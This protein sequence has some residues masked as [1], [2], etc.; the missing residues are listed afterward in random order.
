MAIH[1][2][3]E[4]ART[5]DFSKLD[6]FADRFGFQTASWLAFIAATQRAEPVVASL[7]DGGETVG[8]FTGLVFRRWGLKLLGSPFP[9]WTTDYMGFNLVPGCP[10]S[11][12]LEGL[13][14]FAFKTLGCVHVEIYDRFATEEDARARRFDYALRRGFE[15]DLRR[16]EAT[17]FKS[18]NEACRRCVR[19]A[20]KSGVTIEEAHDADFARDYYAQLEDVFAKQS[21]VP[22][23]KIDRVNALIE[24]VRPSGNLLLLRARDREG[25]CI[26]T[27]IFPAFNRHALFWGGASMREHQHLRPNEALMWHAMRRWKARGMSFLD[28]GGGGEY[29]RKYGGY[30]IAVPWMRTSRFGAVSRHRNLAKTLVGTRQKYLGAARQWGRA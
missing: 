16:D 28:M 30:D 8:W 18:M 24:H 20:E 9:G 6:G 21:L 7:R 12:A 25:R 22:T 17:L 10:R 27:G 23:Y 15:I 13:R 29:K 4:D 1:Y 2:A 3:L 11:A 14:D 19:K 5:F 26:A